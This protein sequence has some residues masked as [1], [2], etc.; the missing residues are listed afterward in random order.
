MIEA[1]PN[2]VIRKRSVLV[3]G[4]RTSVSLEVAFWDELLRLAKAQGISLNAL[5]TRIDAERSGNL[6][7]ALRLYVL[8]ALQGES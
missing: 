3:A 7:S 8:K 4:H 2:A 1:D 6:S 5:V